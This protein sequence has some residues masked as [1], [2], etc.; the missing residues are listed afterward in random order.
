MT[1]FPDNDF[2]EICQLVGLLNITW[3]WAE[4]Y[5]ALSI[6]IIDT[7]VPQLRSHKQL[8]ISL[9]ARLTY[10]KHALSDVPTLKPI[11][12][13]GRALAQTFADLKDQRN[14][15]IHGAAWQTGKDHFRT[16]RF[17]TKGR[18]AHIQHQDFNKA[19]GV[20]LG[21]KIVALVDMA[22]AFL[23]DVVAVIP[24]PK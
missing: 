1:D 24:E 18:N 9:T 4:N 13:R 7:S 19:S 10:L 23:K 11:Q 5:L 6:A 2:N 14:T 15:L 8:P 22:A 17:I 20:E 16:A 3:G 21:N 12:E